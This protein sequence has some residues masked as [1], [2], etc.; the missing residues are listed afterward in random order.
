MSSTKTVYAMPKIQ[1]PRISGIPE[2]SSKNHQSESPSLGYMPQFH[3]F[4]LHQR[5]AQRL[6]EQ[7]DHALGG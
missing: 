6:A 2:G 3:V 7:S 4:L 5:S 1:S